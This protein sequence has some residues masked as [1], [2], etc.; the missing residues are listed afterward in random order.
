VP[1][2]EWKEKGVL[3]RRREEGKERVAEKQSAEKAAWGAVR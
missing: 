1:L 2:R 3:R